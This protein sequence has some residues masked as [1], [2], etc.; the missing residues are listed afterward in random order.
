MCFDCLWLFSI[1]GYLCSCSFS[2]VYINVSVSYVMLTAMPSLVTLVLENTAVTDVG[3]K[4]YASCAPPLLEN[5]DLSRTNVTQDIF[6]PLQGI[7]KEYSA[8]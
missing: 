7:I 3:V 6:V 4:H 8:L 2:D 1:S 5:L